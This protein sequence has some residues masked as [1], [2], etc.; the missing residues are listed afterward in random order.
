MVQFLSDFKLL[1]CNLHLRISVPKKALLGGWGGATHVPGLN[2][3]YRLLEFEKLAVSL[4]VSNPSLC[5]FSPSQELIL[6]SL[7]KSCYLKRPNL[8]L[9]IHLLKEPVILVKLRIIHSTTSKSVRK[10]IHFLKIVVFYSLNLFNEVQIIS[11]I[12]VL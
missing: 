4:S 5:H 12:K 9:C 2:F 11:Y 10:D 6:L 7:W 1:K 3:K 8:L